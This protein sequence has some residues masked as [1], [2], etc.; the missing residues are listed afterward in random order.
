M[1][2][3]YP[4]WIA[5]ENQGLVNHENNYPYLNSHPNLVCQNKPHWSSGAYVDSVSTYYDVTDIEMKALVDMY[6]AVGTV[7]YAGDDSFMDY[8]AGTIFD[9]CR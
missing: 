1:L 7:I 4:K 8:R 9:T 3:A 2:D 5:Q 6:G